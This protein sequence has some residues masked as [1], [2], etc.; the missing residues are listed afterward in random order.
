MQPSNGMSQSM[1]HR[2]YQLAHKEIRG[3]SSPDAAAA[4]LRAAHELIAAR[5]NSPCH[6]RTKLL[7]RRI[8]AAGI[9]HDINSLVRS[10]AVAVRDERQLVLLPP[11]AKTRARVLPVAGVLSER[12]P[13][14]WLPAVV[15]ISSVF[16]LSTCHRRLQH[17]YPGALDVLG[18]ATDAVAAA[19]KLGL[20]FSNRSREYAK[21]HDVANKWFVEINTLAVP[22]AFRRNGLLWWFQALTTFLVRISGQVARSIGEHPSMRPFLMADIAEGSSVNSTRRWRRLP[23]AS[24]TISGFVWSSVASFDV[25]LHV[26]M[27]DVCG[28]QADEHGLRLCLRSLPSNLERLSAHNISSGRLFVASDS[29]TIINQVDEARPAFDVFTL[30]L[31]RTQ[32]ERSGRIEDTLPRGH[33]LSA[34]RDAFMELLMLSRAEVIAGAMSSNMPRLALQLRVKPPGMLTPYIPMDKN[35]W[36]TC[37]SCKPYFIV[38]AGNGRGRERLLKEAG[39]LKKLAERRRATW[40]SHGSKP[41]NRKSNRQGRIAGGTTHAL[42][43]SKQTQKPAPLTAT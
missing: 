42:R 1:P 8:P 39:A 11:M 17:A 18:N 33:D 26:R 28:S 31:V 40:P 12:R 14:H 41:G 37:S 22:K 24:A 10:L 15:P 34:V 27:G 23:V 36:C 20:P 16:H 32:Y 13:W 7:F 3:I 5:H 2:I 21:D 29:Q 4:D 35:E 9:S 6:P 43:A 19:S 25:G 38:G 30:S